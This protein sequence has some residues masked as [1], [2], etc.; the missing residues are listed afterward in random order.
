MGVSEGCFSFGPRSFFAYRCMN[1][2]V[3][4]RSAHR[5]SCA[6]VPPVLAFA[7]EEMLRSAGFAEVVQ[8]V[9]A[10]WTDIQILVHD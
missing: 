2:G 6:S 1:R 7:R 5:P 8:W 4:P 3:G 10:E 9:S